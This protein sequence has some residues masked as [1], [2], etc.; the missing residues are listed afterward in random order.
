MNIK[1]LLLLF[2]ALSAMN[3]FAQNGRIVGR[4]YDQI[5]NE[6]LSFATVQI[7]ELSIGAVADIDGNYKIENI[8]QGT[9]TVRASFTG[10]EPITLSEILVTSARVVTLDFA[11]KE[12]GALTEVV[13]EASPFKNRDESPLSVNTLNATELERYPGA[14]RDVSRVIQALPGVAQIPSFRNDI[15]IRGGSP[16]ENRFYLDGIEVP[17]INH[18]ATQGSSGGPVG[19]LNINFIREVE[20]YSGAFPANRANGLSSVISFSQKRGNSDALITNF[21]LGSSDFA[22]TF[23][24]PLGSK[25]NFIFSYRVSY[26]QLLF[27][28]L[29][30]PFL[31]TYQDSQFKI[32]HDI[33][34]KNRLTFIGLGALDQFSLNQS[35]NDGVTDPE[36]LR[37]NNYILGNI[38]VNNQW[39]YTIGAKWTHFSKNSY[40]TLVVSRNMLKNTAIKY[41]DNIELPENLILNYS[42]FEAENKF[43]FEHDY[44]KNGWKI[45]AGVGYEY[46]NYFNETLNQVVINGAPVSIDFLSRI[47]FGKFSLFGQ[48]SRRFFNERLATSFGLRTDFSNFTKSLMNPLEQISP[49]LSLSY[50]VTD[51]ISISGNVGRYHQLP[52]YTILGYRNAQNQL[53]NRENDIKYIRVDQFV[54]GAN[55]KTDWKSKISVEGFYKAY[56]RYPF[57]LR[58][59]VSIANLGSDF[60]VIGNEPVASISEGRAMGVELLYQQRL[61]KGFYGIVAYT[62]VLSEFKDKTGS[63]IPSSWDNRN[64]VSLSVGKSFKKNWDVGVRWRFSGGSP[65]TPIDIATSSLIPVWNVTGR[66]LPDYNQ[67]NAQRLGSFHQMDIRV[68]KKFFF[69][70]WNMNF[71][72]DIQN[73]YNFQ[74][75]T[76]PILLVV[77]DD[78][79]VP[80]VDPNNPNAYQTEQ[81]ANI[82]GTVL[83]T[84]GIII[85]FSAKKK[86][87]EPITE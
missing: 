83:P 71:Y 29:Q 23:D 37:R 42:S 40:Q 8:P 68:D 73:L 22:L 75:E 60:G 53:V 14:N 81:L 41:R 78:N 5:N 4:I 43:R 58:D 27:Q 39:N 30:L 47:G 35:V 6:P 56:S 63:Y 12:K 11:M 13:I 36:T 34:K 50:D 55:Y 25:T 15:I 66:G 67:L 31:P 19:L 64:I 49:M 20:F 69:P 62:F 18:F 77:T 65:F 46:A 24:G 52:S 70:S 38:P 21:A 79:N 26:L 7:V 59:S 74:V 87:K 76:A 85:E 57:S 17:N 82:S 84:I 33:N 48:V 72:I 44:L 10:Y 61:Y 45:N 1:S 80:L 51:K 54:I 16:G 86:K 32:D 2:A 3:S 9:Y 28:A